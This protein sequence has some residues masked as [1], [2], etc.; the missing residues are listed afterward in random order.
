MGRHLRIS[1][2]VKIV[3]GRHELENGYLES[4]WGDNILLT[5]VDHPGPVT[6]VVGEPSDEDLLRAAAVTARYSDGK[7]E[8]KVRVSITGT[9][10]PL[11][12]EVAPAEDGDLDR[13]RI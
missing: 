9:D 13:W 2:G 4:R 5:T 7:R 10:G 12:V 3:V 6:L 1:D 11:E 8:E